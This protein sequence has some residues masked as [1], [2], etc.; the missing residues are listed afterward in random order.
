VPLIHAAATRKDDCV[1]LGEFLTVSKTARVVLGLPTGSIEIELAVPEGHARVEQLLPLANSLT[2]RIIE[3]TVAQLGEEGRTI[4]C[5]A[6]CGA[7]CRQLVPIAE[8]EARRIRDLVDALP[9]PRKSIVTARFDEAQQRLDDAGLLEPLR[10]R[11]GWDSTRRREF[12][13]AYFRQGI[14]CPF[15]E[16]ESCSIHSERPIMCRE[17]LVT[18]PPENC[19]DPTAD[20]VEGVKLPASVW[21]AVARLG[22][23]D[24]QAKTLAWVPLV[25]ALEWAGRHPDSLPERPAE[26]LIKSLFQNIASKNDPV[27]QTN[28]NGSVPSILP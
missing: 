19:T 14:P 11:A 21:P 18:S 5:R 7:C 12:G 27:A 13:L 10:E 9:E 8:P 26:Q 1:E 3:L 25:L 16:N 24:P 28:D 4:S 22:T 6:G 17:Y 2:E 23:L 15:L 20:R